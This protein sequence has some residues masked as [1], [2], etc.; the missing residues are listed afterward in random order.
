MPSVFIFFKKWGVYTGPGQGVGGPEA[1][2]I[3][4]PSLEKEYTIT[5]T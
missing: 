5:N 2:T 4:G 3:L 1:H